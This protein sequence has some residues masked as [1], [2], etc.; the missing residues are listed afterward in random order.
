M[1]MKN[2]LT[3]LTG[4]ALTFAMAGSAFAGPTY[5]I[6]NGHSYFLT[7]PGIWDVAEAEAVSEGGHL[8]TMND[9]A[10]NAWVTSIFGHYPGGRWIGLYQLPGSPEPGGGWVWISGEPVTYTNWG[11]GEPS[12]SPPSENYAELGSNTSLDTWNDWSHLRWDWALW[13]PVPGIV[14]IPRVIPAPG[15][16][17]LA[18]IGAGVVGWLRRRRTL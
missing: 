5:Y 4:L 9:A 18:G 14:E 8:V 1:M 15:A 7:A 16:F 3:I 12:N 10:E 13:G 17:L 11:A 2:V 6:Y